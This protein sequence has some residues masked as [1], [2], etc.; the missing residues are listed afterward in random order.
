MLHPPAAL[1]LGMQG[2]HGA[3][4]RAKQGLSGRRAFG[5]DGHLGV[6]EEQAPCCPVCPRPRP[7]NTMVPQA[8]PHCPPAELDTH[9]P[10]GPGA[11]WA[12]FGH[13][14]QGERE[15]GPQQ[16]ASWRG[17]RAD[18]CLSGAARTSQRKMASP[19][20]RTCCWSGVKAT[21]CT[22]SEWPMYTWGQWVSHMGTLTVA[23]AWLCSQH[24]NLADL[25]GQRLRVPHVT[26]GLSRQSEVTA[27]PLPC[28]PCP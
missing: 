25:L 24:L 5:G 22:G 17:A 8:P 28:P 14:R 21:A 27:L 2:A 12:C 1:G 4:S 7:G 19:T 11:L 16:E 23:R 15:S 3:Q 6:G 18:T 9:Q 26:L 10:Q 13:C 20:L